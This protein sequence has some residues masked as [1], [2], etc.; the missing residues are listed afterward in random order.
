MV[1]TSKQNVVRG[2]VLKALET[3]G[4]KFLEALKHFYCE[5]CGA[6]LE[7]TKSGKALRHTRTAQHR[8]RYSDLQQN[9]LLANIVKDI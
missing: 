4:V 8:R 9:K 7:T 1:K 6:T 2:A 5:Y 3:Q